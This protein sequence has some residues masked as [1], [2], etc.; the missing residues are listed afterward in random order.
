MGSGEFLDWKVMIL[1]YSACG[2]RPNVDLSGGNNC[3]TG[4][5]REVVVVVGLT[6]TRTVAMLG[7]VKMGRSDVEVENEECSD[8]PPEPGRDRHDAE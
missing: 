5:K 1:C 4:S 2:C 8:S 3:Y 7:E 6:V